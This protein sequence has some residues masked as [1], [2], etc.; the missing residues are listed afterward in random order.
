MKESVCFL[1]NEDPA[2]GPGTEESIEGLQIGFSKK[3][4][5][6]YILVGV[7][8]VQFDRADLE[9]FGRHPLQKEVNQDLND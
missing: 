5:V 4:N 6:V 9:G 3:S 8:P 1:T 7:S 2:I